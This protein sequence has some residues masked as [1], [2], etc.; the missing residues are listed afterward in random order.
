MRFRILTGNSVLGGFFRR[1]ACSDAVQRPRWAEMAALRTEI[2]EIVTGLGMLGLASVDE[3]LA[4]RPSEMVGVEGHHYDKLVAARAD[5]KYGL[6]FEEAWANGVAFA[7]AEDGLRDRQPK[8]VE[9]KGPHKLP[10]YDQVPADLRVDYVYLVSCKYGSKLLHNVSPSHLFD[11]LLVQRHGQRVD[12][13]ADVAPDEYQHLYRACRD[14]MGD[15]EL[16]ATIGE[17]DRHGRGR[18]KEAFQ[19]AWPEPLAEPYRWF[20]I[21]VSRA[22]AERW[23]QALEDRALR[24]QTLWRLLRLQPAPYF[25]LGTD[26]S[27]EPLRYRVDTPWDFRV[28][29]RFKSLDAWPEARGQPVVCWRADLVEISTGAPVHVDGHVEVRWSHGRFKGSP[30]AKVYLDTPHLETPGYTELS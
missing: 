24:E 10:G 12:W 14:Y 13:Y 17:L 25:V 23:L 22:S 11:R 1:T 8:R 28:R 26:T 19:G 9:W 21:A 20:A 6:Q 2:T 29:Y 18:L 5:G 7:A 30:E 3:A 15:S 16:P 4:A 27:W